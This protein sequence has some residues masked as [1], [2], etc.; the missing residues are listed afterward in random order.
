MDD[1]VLFYGLGKEGLRL[2]LKYIH[3]GLGEV[4][5]QLKVQ[6]RVCFPLPPGSLSLAEAA[7]R[8]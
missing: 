7:Q 6:T 4:L 3:Q 1:F 8:E 2:T 5:E